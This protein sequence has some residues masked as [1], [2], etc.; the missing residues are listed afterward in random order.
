MLNDTLQNLTKPIS[1]FPRMV[2][3]MRLSSL[4]TSPRSQ[5]KCNQ[6]TELGPVLAVHKLPTNQ[7]CDHKTAMQVTF[8]CKL[9][10]PH[11]PKRRINLHKDRQ[12]L[13][14]LHLQ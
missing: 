13:R 8:L 10:H 12:V 2:I 11:M 4:P 6:T 14:L 1:V 3:Q 5:V 9:G 7:Y